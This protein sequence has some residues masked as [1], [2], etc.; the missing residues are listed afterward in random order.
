MRS[1]PRPTIADCTA[2]PDCRVVAHPSGATQHVPVRVVTADEYRAL[3]EAREAQAS[4]D[5]RFAASRAASTNAR[6][7]RR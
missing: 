7:A 6:G 3:C 4:A 5:R 1:A 2:H